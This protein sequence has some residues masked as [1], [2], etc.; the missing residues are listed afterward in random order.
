M[1]RSH[2]AWDFGSPNV[3]RYDNSDCMWLCNCTRVNFFAILTLVRMLLPNQQFRELWMFTLFVYLYV[4]SSPLLFFRIVPWLLPHKVYLYGSFDW[5]ERQWT[6]PSFFTFWGEIWLK[7]GYFITSELCYR[8]YDS[9]KRYNNCHLPLSHYLGGAH[10]LQCIDKG[11]CVLY[12]MTRRLDSRA[13]LSRTPMSGRN[14]MLQSN[15]FP[16]WLYLLSRPDL[17][18]SNQQR[19]P[20]SVCGCNSWYAFWATKEKASMVTLLVSSRFQ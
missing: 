13:Q 14:T 5:H 2:T 1:H 18:A 20:C 8:T 15:S 7:S 10:L 17:H 9:P 3:M 19:Y 4:A 16:L 6:T 11:L 12:T